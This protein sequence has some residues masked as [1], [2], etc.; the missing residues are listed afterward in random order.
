MEKARCDFLRISIA[1]HVC[2][3]AYMV[4]LR[5]ESKQILLSIEINELLT[6]TFLRVAETGNL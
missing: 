2:F 1:L 5:L 3:L 4:F 6:P